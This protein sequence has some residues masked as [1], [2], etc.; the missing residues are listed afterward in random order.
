[1]KHKKNDTRYQHRLQPRP[2][3][4]TVAD[5]LR[6]GCCVV[7][8]SIHLWRWWML[9]GDS[10]YSSHKPFLASA[11]CSCPLVYSRVST[12][13]RNLVQPPASGRCRS[14]VLL[15]YWARS[16]AIGST[17]QGILWRHT[18]TEVWHCKRPE[19]L[20]AL[21]SSYHALRVNTAWYSKL[22]LQSPVL[23][24]A[25]SLGF[26][27]WAFSTDCLIHCYKDNTKQR[28]PPFEK[29]QNFHPKHDMTMS[30]RGSRRQRIQKTV[31]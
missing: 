21:P 31:S 15:F 6:Y 26:T 16:T 30:Y 24:R 4:W 11:T 27:V 13:Y 12:C 9:L 19:W 10:K 22:T 29:L 20:Q 2:Q 25:Y 8:M 28:E 3:S 7:Y 14:D 1:M 17:E 5:S 23:Q 18:W